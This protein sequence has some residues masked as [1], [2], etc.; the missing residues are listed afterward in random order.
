VLNNEEQMLDTSWLLFVVWD[1]SS[2][3]QI[4]RLSAMYHLSLVI[5]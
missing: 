5:L 2:M 1:L 3:C 4:W